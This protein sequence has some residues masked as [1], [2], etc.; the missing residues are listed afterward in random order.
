MSPNQRT[1]PLAVALVVFFAYT[2][3][4]HSELGC[5]IHRVQTQ[6]TQIVSELK[7]QARSK[8]AATSACLSC[9]VNIPALLEDLGL[10]I[11]H[12]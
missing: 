1:L 8:I 12:Q 4:P 3:S 11:D 2:D 5:T 9:I 10:S 6:A 7:T